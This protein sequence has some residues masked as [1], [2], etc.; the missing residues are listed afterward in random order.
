MQ[1]DD[2]RWLLIA[3][4]SQLKTT[5]YTPNAQAW[6]ITAARRFGNFTPY[7]A[8][9]D[10]AKHRKN[11]TITS[12]KTGIPDL[13]AA[14]QAFTASRNLGQSRTTVGLRWDFY[15]N[16]ALKLEYSHIRIKDNSWGSFLPTDPT[17]IRME[18]RH[19]NT[20]GASVDVT[21]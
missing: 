20:I 8:Y 9:A 21:F 5:R 11:G 14:V 17:N 18:N 1:W 15:R 19:V 2:T 4:Y 7:L 10:F 12:E 3:E 13:D 16:T 6:E